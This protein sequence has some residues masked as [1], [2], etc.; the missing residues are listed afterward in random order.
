MTKSFKLHL[1]APN[2]CS[3]LEARQSSSQIVVPPEDINAFYYADMLRQG[4]RR[5]GVFVYRP[6]CQNCQACMSLRVEVDKFVPSKRFQRIINKNKD[7]TYRQLPLRWEEEH[8]QLYMRYQR[9]RHQ[10]Q[11]DEH[12]TRA[13]YKEFILN[14]QVNSA[15]LEYRDTNN[16]LQMVSLID[17]ND[18]GIS[19]V[20]TFYDTDNKNSLGHYGILCQLDICKL[21]AK[22]WLYLGYWVDGCSKLNYKTNYQ[23]AEIFHDGKWIPYN[24]E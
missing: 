13:D 16:Q 21:L 10:E 6:H 22:P 4:F 20:Y 15:L 7:L 18:D 11:Q 8:F 1:S 24:Q 5:S 23:P 19:A 9:S 12:K 2:H 14:S 17:I 3:Y